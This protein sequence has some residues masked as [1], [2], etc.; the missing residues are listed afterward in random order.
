VNESSAIRY[1]GKPLE[2]REDFKLLTGKGRYVDD[3][4]LRGM[5]HMAVLRSPHGHAKVKHVDLSSAKAAPGVRAVLSGKDFAGKI[6]PITPNWVIPGSKVPLRPVVAV[7]RVRFVGECIAVVVAQSLAQ[8][9]DALGLI[10]VEYELLPVVTDEET[11]VREGAPQLHQHVPHNVTTVYKVRGG[12]YRKA[13]ENA[14]HILRLRLVNNRLIPTCME[15]R[16][17]V[18][19][20]GPDGALTVYMGSQVPHMHRPGP[21]YELIGG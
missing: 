3:I 16:S 6:Q 11:A 12:D 20:P 14:D 21:C 4:Q 18:A 8:A 2:R 9:F 5:L 1:I 15:T 7:D 19:D 13:V 10:D 17:I